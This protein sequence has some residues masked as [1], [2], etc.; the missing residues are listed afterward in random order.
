MATATDGDDLDGDDLD[1]AKGC[2]E[3][4]PAWAGAG[5]VASVPVRMLLPPWIAWVI[6]RTR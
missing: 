4:G 5:T 6:P 3:A 2:A 1:G